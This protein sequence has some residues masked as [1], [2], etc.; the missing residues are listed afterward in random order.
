MP[1]GP[2]IRCSS[3][4]MIRS[5]GRSGACGVVFA[6]G[7]C[8]S[9][10]GWRVGVLDLGRAEA[11]AVAVAVDLAE[12][13]LHLAVPR[14]LGELVHRGDQQRRQAAVDLLVHH[15]RPGMPSPRRLAW[16]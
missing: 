5:G 9:F 12:E 6:G 10:F 8:L 7:Q 16:R 4:W 14:H 11:V 15:Q 1:S 13:H 3:S 2:L